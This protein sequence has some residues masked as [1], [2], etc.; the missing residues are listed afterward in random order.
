MLLLFSL[1]VEVEQYLKLYITCRVEPGGELYVADVPAGDEAG[2]GDAGRAARR[3]H[4]ALL[5]PPVPPQSPTQWL[6]T[7]LLHM[8]R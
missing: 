6:K 4:I 8:R 2:H 3:R 1:S 5:H 7:P